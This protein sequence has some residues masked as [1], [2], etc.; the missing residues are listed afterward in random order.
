MDDKNKQNTTGGD[1]PFKPQLHIQPGIKVIQPSAS[2]LEELKNQKP[3]SPPAPAKSQSTEIINKSTETQPVQKPT[4]SSAIYPE[5]TKDAD[6]SAQIA[7]SAGAHDSS[8]DKALISPK[9]IFVIRIVTGFLLA[10]EL[11]TLYVQFS[12]WRVI[13]SQLDFIGL[14][15]I[16]FII[17]LLSA[18]MLLK[19]AARSVYVFIAAASLC[20]VVVSFLSLY[21]ATHKSTTDNAQHQQLSRQQIQYSIDATNQNKVYTPEQKKI[22]INNLKAQPGYAAGNDSKLKAKRYATDAYILLISVGPIVFYTRPKIK[23]AFT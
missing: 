11:L 12:V 20:I 19:D 7:H 5:A 2:L 21:A 6:I 13:H 18:M 16:M 10:S 22:L 8:Q 17:V 4:L 23:E 3:E 9:R 1:D 14:L 15:V